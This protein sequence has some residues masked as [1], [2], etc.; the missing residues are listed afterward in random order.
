MIL[1]TGATGKTG[2][3]AVEQLI[4]RKQSVRVLVRSAE[5]GADL[6]AKG[7]E[8]VVGSMEDAGVWT[9]ALAG[10]QSVYFLA[11][12]DPSSEDLVGRGKRIVDHFATALQGPAGKSVVHVVL[13]SSI[14]AQHGAGN[15]PVKILHHAEQKLGTTGKKVTAIRA[16]Y[17]MENAASMV[18]L[19]KGQGILPALFDPSLRIPMI[20]SEDI[21]TLVAEVLLDPPG[22]SSIVEL[23]GPVAYSYQDVAAA[24]SETLG[25]TVNVVAVPPA[26]IVPALQQAGFSENVAGLYAEMAGGIGSGVMVFT[27]GN[28]RH[29]RGKT[30]LAELA[31]QFS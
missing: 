26:G 31:K 28:A 12:P 9:S 2:A 30:T 23:E 6:K 1:V 5:K 17:F 16:S 7:A 8:V 11:P 20:A 3:V 22:T 19:M 21:G 13:L 25:K 18:G 10:V 24:F 29:V 27:G 4:A 15:G 14:G